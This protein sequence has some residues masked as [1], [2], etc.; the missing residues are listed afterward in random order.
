MTETPEYINTQ[1]ET[2]KIRRAGSGRFEGRPILC[3]VDDPPPM[4][5]GIEAPM[6]LTRGT[7]DWL[8]EQF[9]K[10]DAEG[11]A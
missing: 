8:R 1:R 10:L 5:S 2:I 7:R 3:I 9:D 4:G 11:A 6:L